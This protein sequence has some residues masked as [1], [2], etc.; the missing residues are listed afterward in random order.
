MH[1][2]GL[3]PFKSSIDQAIA[4]LY[5]MRISSSL[6]S[7]SSFN[8]ADIITYLAF[9]GLKKA[10]FKCPGSSFKDNPF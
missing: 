4:P 6:C 8:V 2:E 1:I 10:Y 3:I 5:F 9:S 7:S